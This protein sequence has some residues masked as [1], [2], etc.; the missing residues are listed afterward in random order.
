MWNAAVLD[1]GVAQIRP[2]TVGDAMAHH[3]GEDTE[4]VHWL[5]GGRSSPEEV[6]AY[7]RR[8]EAEWAARGLLRAFGVCDVATNSLVGTVDVRVGQPYLVPGQANLAYGIYPAWRRRGFAIRAVALAGRYVQDGGIARE[9]VIRTHP[10]NV[11]S[12]SIAL[13]SGFR[14]SHAAHEGETRLDWYIK[15]VG[16]ADSWEGR[17]RSIRG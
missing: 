8:C 5:S 2:L 1:D 13:R 11:A 6:V 3:A 14:Y 7:L 17:S 16:A 9:L 10:D 4:I 15:P 12:V